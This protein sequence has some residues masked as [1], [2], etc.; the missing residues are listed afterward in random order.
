LAKPLARLEEVLL[1]SEAPGAAGHID[2]EAGLADW[3]AGQAL[4]RSL[5][6]DHQPQP[7]GA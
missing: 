1:E 3:S 6:V 4:A 7:Q 5:M 2:G